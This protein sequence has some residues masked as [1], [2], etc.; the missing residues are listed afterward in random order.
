MS[1]ASDLQ[2]YFVPKLHPSSIEGNVEEQNKPCSR[3]SQSTSQAAAQYDHV[4]DDMPAPLMAA[5]EAIVIDSGLD[6]R[7]QE[8]VRKFAYHISLARSLNKGLDVVSLLTKPFI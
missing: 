8:R 2:S 4:R 5:C 3:D 6:Q 7:L 1:A